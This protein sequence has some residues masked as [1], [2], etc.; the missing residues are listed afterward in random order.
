[1]RIEVPNQCDGYKPE[2]C[3]GNIVA[4][5]TK[6]MN[7]TKTNTLH[8]FDT[9]GVVGAPS[10]VGKVPILFYVKDSPTH[11]H[12][13]LLYYDDYDSVCFVY[14]ESEHSEWCKQTYDMDYDKVEAWDNGVE[15]GYRRNWGIL[16]LDV[17]HKRTWHN[18]QIMYRPNLK[19]KDCGHHDGYPTQPSN[20]TIPEKKIKRVIKQTER[21]TKRTPH[22]GCGKENQ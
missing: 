14:P 22:C 10:P 16:E 18:G 13:G 9:V 11:Y 19:I 12:A 1:M 20:Q 6:T 17:E 4:Q 7:V 21:K 3:G 15:S 8:Q 5:T 2:S